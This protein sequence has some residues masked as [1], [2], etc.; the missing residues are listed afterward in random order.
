MTAIHE[1]RL[2]VLADFL[3]G[4]EAGHGKNFNIDRW[5]DKNKCR[6]VA[7]AMGWACTI[8]S[9]KAE[10]LF[11]NSLEM[12]QFNRS[13]GFQA[14]EE[15]FGLTVGEALLLFSSQGYGDE[16]NENWVGPTAS[17]VAHKIYN[18]LAKNAPQPN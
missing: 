2:T 4:F 11:L 7:C 14:A 10:G 17:E 3:A 1:K 18:H 15:F 5:F 8:P 16:C 12:P 6:T 13:G 9:L